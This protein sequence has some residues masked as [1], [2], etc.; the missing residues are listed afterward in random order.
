M[1]IFISNRAKKN[2]QGYWFGLF[3]PILV[4]MGCSFLSMGILVNSDGPVSEFDYIDYVFLTFLM[5]G[6]LVVWPF[7]AWLLTRSD[8]GEH[9][10]RRKGAYMSL[11]LYVFWIVFIV[12]NS[13]IEALG[14]E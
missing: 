10:S 5:A 9:F 8:P 6:H 2:M 11:K 4:G 7:V 1:S 3:V 14:G 13:I 12:F